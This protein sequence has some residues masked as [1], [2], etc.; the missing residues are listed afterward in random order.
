M[1][2]VYDRGTRWLKFHR[3][4]V[5]VIDIEEATNEKYWGGK[6]GEWTPVLFMYRQIRMKHLQVEPQTK[7]DQRKKKRE[8][9]ER[10]Q[11]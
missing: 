6:E 10:M 8:E 1:T 7:K 9:I 4:N 11:K 2:M 5:Q 3:A